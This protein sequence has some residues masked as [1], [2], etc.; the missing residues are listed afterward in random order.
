MLDFKIVESLQCILKKERYLNL[1]NVNNR[2]A[3][4][5]IRLSSHN[6]AIN[7]TKW[8]NVQEDMKICKNYEKKEIENEIR[9]IFSCNKYDNIRR[10]A[11]NDINK[12]NNIKL[13]IGNKVEKLKLFFVEGF[14]KLLMYLDNS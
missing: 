1:H 9:I 8:Y 2:S 12:V 3:I 11:F 6:F 4:T 14:L 7:T 5:K 13:Q 10:K